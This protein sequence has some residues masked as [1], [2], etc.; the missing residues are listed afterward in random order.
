MVIKIA[1]KYM[2]AFTNLGDKMNGANLSISLLS[3]GYLTETISLI[4]YSN[5]SIC[6]WS[7]PRL[8][9]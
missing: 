7:K 4:T 9:M 8:C 6:I 3:R 5:M 2:H 1:Q